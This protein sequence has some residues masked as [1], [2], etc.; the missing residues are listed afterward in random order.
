MRRTAAGALL[1]AALVVTDGPARPV[2]LLGAYN[3]AHDPDL[4]GDAGWTPTLRAA[5]VLPTP[6]VPLVVGAYAGAG[7]LPL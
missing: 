3:A 7:R 6:L 4:G 1:A 5:R 2:D